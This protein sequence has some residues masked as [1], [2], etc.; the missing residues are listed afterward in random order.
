MSDSIYCYPPDYTVLKNK[1]GIHN[2]D[3]LNEIERQLV[4][5]RLE[6]NIPE[7]NFDLDHLK[8]IHRHL[9][10]DIYE[11]AGKIRLVEI[12]KGS[13]Q[14][15]LQKYIE[16]GMEDVH[17]RIVKSD[18]LQNLCPK[19]FSRKAGEIIGDINYV[20]P[21]R[22]GNG[23]TQLLFLK[24]LTERAGYHLD[25]TCLEREPWIEASREAHLGEYQHLAQWIEQTITQRVKNKQNR[26]DITQ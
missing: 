1:L 15:Q 4:L 22:E 16:T 10:Q 19:E 6:E 20:H 26:D 9:F 21:F 8:A 25:L 3:E 2:A 11:W 12:S 5:I 24:Q 7:G 17:R 13:S 18:Y 23:R 14:F